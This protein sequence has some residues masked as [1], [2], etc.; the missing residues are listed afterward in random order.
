[1]VLIL[2]VAFLVGKLPHLLILYLAV[3]LHE[4]AHFVACKAVGVKT[5]EIRFVAYGLNLVTEH[6]KNPADAMIVSLAG[7]VFS[8]VLWM[9]S[10]YFPSELA[11]VFKISNMGVFLLNVFP[12]LPLD[13]GVFF[14]NYMCTKIGYMKS[15]RYAMELTRV[16][17]IVF[18]LFGMIFLMLSK[19]NI[20]LLVISSFLLYNL[21]EERKKAFVL[22]Q[23]IY[24]KSHEMDLNVLKVCH[25]AITKGV[26]LSSLT[27]YFGYNFVC[28]FFVYDEKMKLVGT[29]SQGEVVDAL[30]EHG[31]GITA[32]EALKEGERDEHKRKGL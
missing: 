1:M 25:R 27:E 19:Y 18:A 32:E 26:K 21:K 9:V 15:H 30:I 20:S 29:L 12:A 2:F 7:P 28:H 31:M 23:M 16:T 10:S 8:W 22:K 13:G 5:K 17:A 4:M 6:I 3:F 24:T 11:H 14:K